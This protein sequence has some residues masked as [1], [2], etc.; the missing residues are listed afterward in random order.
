MAKG[1][2]HALW[3]A[4]GLFFAVTSPIWSTRCGQVLVTGTTA[5]RLLLALRV[6]IWSQL[7]RLSM[8]FYEREMGGRIMTRMTTDVDALSTL[9]QSGLI[10]AI[11]ALFTFVGVGIALVA[12]NW[13]LG[14]ATL[15]VLLPLSVA[16]SPTG[17]CRPG[18]TH[19]PASASPW[20]TPTCRRAS[21]AC[22]S[23]R[24]S[25]ARSA[26]SAISGGDRQLS[27]RPLAGP[28]A[29]APSTSRSSSSWP[30][31]P[32]CWCSGWARCSSPTGR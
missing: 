10:N 13:Q 15:S 9:L 12:W 28:A 21:R 3:V 26:T 6:R 24:R 18:P 4:A 30:T 5:E 16:T 25:C 29:G 19:R 23:P 17:G 14:L 27:R 31:W 20:S 2:Q 22:A 1:S 8:D 11:V 7:Q 32:R